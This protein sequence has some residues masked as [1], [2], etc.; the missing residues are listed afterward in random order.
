MTIQID[1]QTVEVDGVRYRKES[2]PRESKWMP[3]PGQLIQVRD[4][5]WMNWQVAIFEEYYEDH[6]FEWSCR[7]DNWKYARPLADDKL[8]VGRTFAPEGAKWFAPWLEDKW[9]WFKDKPHE[10]DTDGYYIGGAGSCVMETMFLPTGGERPI[11]LWE[12]EE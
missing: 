9:A 6:T 8:L 7:Y 11:K 3:R 10:D 4:R 2:E 5:Y 12:D 1:E